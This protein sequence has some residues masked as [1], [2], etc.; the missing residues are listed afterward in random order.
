MTTKKIIVAIV[1][2]SIILAASCFA[3]GYRAGEIVNING[4]VNMS[5]G[6]DNPMNSN[7]ITSV[8]CT[9]KMWQG[10]TLIMDQYH[11]G[12]VTDLGDNAT[13]AKLFGDSDY[14]LT[15][16]DMNATYISIGND[17]GG[18]ATTSTVLPAEW[19]RTIATVTDEAQ[20]QLNLTCT[21]YPDDSGPYTADCI[22]LNFE[23]GIGK[24]NNLWA[25]DTFSEVT[26]IDET[27]TINIEFQVSIAHS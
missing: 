15:Q 2:S 18:L 7:E 20:S 21:F 1:I 5:S 23:S 19:N 9:I 13:L 3:L 12:A 10:T 16:Y 26:G 25:Y 11:A 22:G 14:N 17:G 8:H 6:I 4:S 27:F 24:D